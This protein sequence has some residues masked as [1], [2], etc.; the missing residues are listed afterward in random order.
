MLGHFN[1][2]VVVSCD[3]RVTHEGLSMHSLVSLGIIKQTDCD[4]Y[5]YLP[6]TASQQLR[7]LVI[8]LDVCGTVRQ[9]T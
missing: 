3:L 9:Q 8:C 5:P 2:E 4:T 1:D 7:R 6:H